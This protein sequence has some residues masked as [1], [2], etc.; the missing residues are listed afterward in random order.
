MKTKIGL[1]LLLLSTVLVACGSYKALNG[2]REDLLGGIKQ[3]NELVRL[4]DFEKAKQFVTGSAREEFEARA[5]MA[6]DA[7][8]S[9]Y[10]ILKEEFAATTDEESV[11]VEFNYTIPPSP[12][13]KTLVDNQRWSYLYVKEDGRR[14]WRLITPLPEFK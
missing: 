9:G 11:K 2:Y 13:I 6:R 8:I 1:S 12:Q 10:R 14:R 7:K 3:Y 4:G 5:Q